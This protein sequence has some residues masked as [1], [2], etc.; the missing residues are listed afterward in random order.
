VSLVIRRE[1][2]VGGFLMTF[3]PLPSGS[4]IAKSVGI[5]I[6]AH[7]SGFMDY[8]SRYSFLKGFTFA[9][10]IGVAYPFFCFFAA[11]KLFFL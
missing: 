3:A 1:P 9:D 11:E 8:F 2:L 7:K 5:G 6:K 10:S 4:L